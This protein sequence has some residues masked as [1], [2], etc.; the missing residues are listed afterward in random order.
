MLAQLCRSVGARECQIVCL[1]TQ[2]K[3]ITGHTRNLCPRY[4]LEDPACGNGN[5]ALGAYYAQ[6]ICSGAHDLSL[7]FAQGH[8]VNMPA[9]IDVHV[10]NGAVTIGGKAR[11][12]IEGMIEID[13]GPNSGV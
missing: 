7:S 8:S 5:A 11:L 4:G 2:G 12:M 10:R 9:V 13:P 3:D 1:E 6:F